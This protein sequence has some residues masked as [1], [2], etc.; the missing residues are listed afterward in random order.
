MVGMKKTLGL[1]P[2][3]TLAG[4]SDGDKIERL[5]RAVQAQEEQL[6]SLQAQ[7]LLAQEE[8]DKQVILKRVK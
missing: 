2:A 6:Q 8:H 7:Q 3:Y 4:C 1:S 5:E